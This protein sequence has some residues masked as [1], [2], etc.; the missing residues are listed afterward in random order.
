MRRIG[1]TG[2]QGLT[3]E[4]ELLISLAIGAEIETRSPPVL[5]ISSLA[6]GADQIFS[7]EVIRRGGSLIAVI[8]SAGYETTF[9]AGGAR[10]SYRELLA[11]AGEVVSMPFEAP[12]EPAFWAAGR[13]VV[14]LADEVFAVWD[15]APAGGL[16][17]TADIVDYA[18]SRGVPVTVLWPDG[19]SRR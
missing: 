8:P 14:E 2:H 6:E 18:R 16:G 7:R 9:G 11:Q 17:G 4:T 3:H 1:F 5:G 12:G 15:G 19:S 13:R 10:E